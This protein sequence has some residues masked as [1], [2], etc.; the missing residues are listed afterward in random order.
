MR[1]FLLAIGAFALAGSAL[2]FMPQAGTW[3]VTSENTGQPGR[4][5]GLD[6]QNNTLVM[7]MYAYEANGAPTFYLS[8]GAIANNSY[9]GQLNKYAGGQSFGSVPHAGYETGSAGTVSMRF[10]SGVKGYITFPGEEEKEMSRFNFDFSSSPESLKGKWLF[11]SLTSLLPSADYVELSKLGSKGANGSGMVMSTD[12]RLACENQ[13]SGASAGT[14]VCARVS[15][16]GALLWGYSFTINVNDGE[17]IYT[18]AA[19][20][21]VYPAVAR[22][23][24]NA[25][26]VG[27][28]LALKSDSSEVQR[29]PTVED[30]EMLR[31]GI[32]A[33]TD[34]LAATN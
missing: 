23:V 11:S 32:D 14:T 7:Q 2:A 21:V 30:N 29:S 6:V 9:A 20:S 22:R 27:T 28:G 12:G 16:T 10:V 5:F 33:F 24:A 3:I 4:G 25:N 34:M 26:G 13:V 15:A 17:G 18:N 19:G 1:K 31:A 8:A